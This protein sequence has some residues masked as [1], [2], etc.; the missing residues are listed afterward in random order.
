MNMNTTNKALPVTS[1]YHNTIFSLFLFLYL[2]KNSAAVMLNVSGYQK[3]P[4]LIE[5]DSQ[6]K[7]HEI[8]FSLTVYSTHAAR[9]KIS[10]FKLFYL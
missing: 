1:H 9:S 5:T 4:I 6:F 7:N 3:E 10:K 2:G 8:F